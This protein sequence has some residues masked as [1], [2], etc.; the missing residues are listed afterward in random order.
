MTAPLHEQ[1]IDG[2]LFI[3]ENRDVSYWNH[4][5]GPNREDRYLM[6]AIIDGERYKIG[7]HPTLEG[8]KRWGESHKNK[9]NKEYLSW[10][11]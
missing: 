6:S 7:S 10:L 11:A 9:L 8:A 3:V 4:E 5:H 1:L 2:V